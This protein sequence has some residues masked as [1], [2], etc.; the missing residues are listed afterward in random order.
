MSSLRVLLSGIAMSCL[1][2]IG[3]AQTQN[4]FDTNKQFSATVVMSGVPTKGQAGQAE[5]KIYRSGD[6]MRTDL[7]GGMGYMIMDMGQHA[8]Y[9]VM[10]TGM[11]MQLPA[12]GQQQPN[13]FS[14]AQGATIERSPA[15]TDTVDGHAC[16]VENVTVTAQNG[17]STKMKV[18]EADDLKGFPIKVEMQTSHGP[19]TVQ[20]KD[21]SFSD[22]GASL[23]THPSNCQ[24]MP[25]MPGGPHS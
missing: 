12:S 8:N 2:L 23:F 21:V 19:I 18:W 20:Y 6:K 16:K 4:P 13:P 3:Q 10:G 5:M 17:Q 15:G 14:Q 7:P 11:C 24:Q 25:N 22:P 1:A 9:M